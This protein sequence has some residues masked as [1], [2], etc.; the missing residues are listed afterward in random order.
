MAKGMVAICLGLKR[1]RRKPEAA[2]KK[3]WEREAE[4]VRKERR[5]RE[6]E[7]DRKKLWEKE[8]GS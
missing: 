7:A 8:V 1:E 5:E 4:A 6:A 2:R 3:L